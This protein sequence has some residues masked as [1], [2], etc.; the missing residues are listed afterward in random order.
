M[1]FTFASLILIGAAIAAASP[2]N[3]PTEPR[4]L[5]GERGAVDPLV[6]PA[7]AG[8]HVHPSKRDRV[9]PIGIPGDGASHN[10]GSKRGHVDPI[11]NPGGVAQHHHGAWP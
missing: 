2:I 9:D 7:Q 1:Q 10:H 3:G 6:D 11:T 5:L 8:R 4:R